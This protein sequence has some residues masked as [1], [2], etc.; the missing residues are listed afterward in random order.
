MPGGAGPRSAAAARRSSGWTRFPLR[1]RLRT[2]KL[3]ALDAALDRLARLDE[4]M[5]RIVEWR[6]FGGMSE[7]EI[8]T[9][10][11]ISSR[12]VKREWRKARAFLFRELSEGGAR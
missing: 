8:A 7:E 3:L 10:L 12:T 4:R 9:A 6:F 11:G 5:A 2:R 1:A